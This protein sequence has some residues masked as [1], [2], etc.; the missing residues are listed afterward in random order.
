MEIIHISA[1]CYPIAKAGGLGDVV[2]ALPKY[3][4]QAGHFAKV[5]MPMYK[6]KFLYSNQFE[7]DFKGA[8]YL[9]DLYF[10]F[11]IIK[12]ATNKLGYDLYLV[13]ING[14]LDREKIYG[15]DDDTE[16]F[17][18]FQIAVV[19]WMNSWEH[20][21]DIVH[22]HD[23]HTGLIPFMMKHCYAF[24]NKLA[25]VPSIITI[26]NAQYQ[27]WMSWD[28]S[29]Y[30]PHWDTWKYGM[31]D[32]KN[33]INPLASG[34]K[35]AWKITTVSKSYLE[36][37]TQNSNG[38]EKL[39]EY[40]KGKCFGI[41]NGIDNEVWNPQTD[42]YLSYHYSIK[43]ITRGKAENKKKICESFDIIPDLPLIVF[44]GRLVGEK[45]ADILPEAFHQIFTHLKGQCSVVVLGSGDRNI[46]NQLASFNIPYKNYFN[47]YIGYNEEL[48][49]LLYAGADFL[50]MP[51]RVEP[52]GL[53]QMY[54]M[55]YGTI[56]MVR[57][58][59]GLKD[60][61]IDIGDEGGYGIRFNHANI[62]DILYS[63]Q[64]AIDVYSDKKLL[65]LIR[66][67]M[68]DV[69]NSWEKTVANYD[70]IYSF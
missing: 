15:Y 51:S 34:I 47:S 1:E 3:Q 20:N 8:A 6:T 10:E 28:K 23:H 30:I 44:I 52:C 46:E 59:G 7:V 64:R 9:G 62:S 54:A 17:T 42:S 63:T 37:L 24:K 32:W 39:F 56:P 26:H 50:L 66:K 33:M 21:P 25:N 48:S 67:R 57:S 43:T 4:N 11:T 53:N 41:L 36:E 16:R 60:T 58:T 29:F 18:A 5:V 69:D 2:G 12:E 70:A 14:L 38:L 40:E 13:D 49:H 65:G 61:V 68:M 22:C 35:N 27:G 55:R 45:A 19:T 31:L